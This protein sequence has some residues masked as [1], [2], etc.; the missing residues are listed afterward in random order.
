LKIH[1]ILNYVTILFLLLLFIRAITTIDTGYDSLW[2]HLKLASRFSGLYPADTFEFSTFVEKL[3]DGFP[4]LGNY[5]QGVLWR[6]TGTVAGANLLSFLSLAMLILAS[7]KLLK[8]PIWQSTLFLCSIPLVLIHSVSSYTDLPN[9]AFLSLSLIL[10]FSYYKKQDFSLKAY[11][12]TLLPTALAMLIKFQAY[13]FALPIFILVTFIFVFYNYFGQRKEYLKIL[14]IL[15]AG[16]VLGLL[17]ASQGINNYIKYDTITYPLETEFQDDFANLRA[18]SVRD[19]SQFRYYLYSLLEIN[20]YNQNEGVLYSVDQGQPSGF[21]NPSFRMGGFF[22]G[23]LAFWSLILLYISYIRKDYRPAIV[24][25]VI[26]LA[27]LSIGLLSRGFI[28]RY[29]IF[30]PVIFAVATL[31]YVSSIREK[32]KSLYNFIFLIQFLILMFVLRF[33]APTIIPNPNVIDLDEYRLT[34]APDEI[35]IEQHP[36]HTTLYKIANPDI[37]FKNAKINPECELYFLDYEK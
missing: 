28:L 36:R 37:D 26:W 20:L 33:T 8:I 9:A 25:G 16:F 29:W 3:A 4:K 14:I 7:R 27:M 30:L 21:D 1:K 6:L 2:Y 32:E 18:E 10:L 34:N 31:I 17:G 5:L 24:L 23:N 22:V 13:V 35:C 19:F 12:I 11:V 15:F